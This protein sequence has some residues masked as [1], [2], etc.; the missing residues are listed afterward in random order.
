MKQR[1]IDNINQAE[2][3]ERLYQDNKQEFTQCFREIANDYDSEL[4]SFWNIRLTNEN[5]SDGKSMMLADL[6]AIIAISLV[7]GIFVK[8]PAIFTQL[9]EDSFYFK[10]L[11]IIV[12]N[13]LIGYTFWQN[14]LFNQ[15]KILAYGVVIA[16]L[17]FFI[18]LLPSDG[19]DSV[20][21]A[22][23]HVPLFLWCLFGLA[24][25]SFDYSNIL[26]KSGFIRFNGELLIMTGLIILAGGLLSAVTIGLFS[27]I[28]QNIEEFYMEN[29]AVFGGV[30]APIISF[31]LIKTF[32]N[33]TNKIAPVISRVFTPLVLITLIV[34]LISLSFSQSKILEDRNLLILFN[35]M[36]LAVMAIIVFSISELNKVSVRNTNVLILFIL[37]LITIIINSIALIAIIER[38]SEGFTPN[39]T[40]VLVTNLLIFGNLILIT[41]DLFKAYLQPAHIGAVEK[42]VAWYLT[43]YFVWT[44]VAIFVLPFIFGFE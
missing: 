25:V 30:A 10:N 39:R 26:K 42:T 11:A 27:V 9:D 21:L 12:F 40:V 17:L 19:G 23:I 18:N 31:Y 35:V 7:T 33:L 32:P 44:I 5:V 43:I 37:A 6:I 29:V 36:L 28:N 8:L 3:L 4:I 34:Y 15:K 2:M 41:K 22:F 16:I 20:K 13:G 1:I 24:Y 38:V 14:K